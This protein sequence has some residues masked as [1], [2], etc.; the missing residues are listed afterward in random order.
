MMDDRLRLLTE[1]SKINQAAPVFLQSQVSTSRKEVTDVT[2]T[3]SNNGTKVIDPEY[4]ENM[5]V[6]AARQVDD[7]GTVSLNGD[8]MSMQ[9]SVHSLG[10]KSMRTH[11][12]K[13]QYQSEFSKRSQ[14]VNGEKKR[15]RVL[16]GLISEMTGARRMKGKKTMDDPHG[17]GRFL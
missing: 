8:N 16:G 5:S 14:R 2:P 7:V 1:K 15:A 3:D 13:A 10:T 9:E 11:G 6:T 12:I 17:V 4:D